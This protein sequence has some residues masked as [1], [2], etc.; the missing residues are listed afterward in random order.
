MEQAGGN[1][2]GRLPDTGQFVTVEGVRLHSVSAGAGVPVV[3]LHGNA[4]FAHDFA[5]L[6]QALP[7]RGFHAVAFDRPGHG[8]SASPTAEPATV[9]VQARLLRGALQALGIERPIVVG[10]SWGGALALA[11]ALAYEPEVAALV[12]LAPAVY[13]EPPAYGAGNMLLAVPLLSTLLIRLSGAHIGR[14]I[15][16][17]LH[18]AFAPDPLPAD[19]LHSAL[20]SWSRTAQV[21]ATVQD[22]M[23]YSPAT[24]ALS[25]R[26]NAV[27]V[28]TVIMTGDADQL[29]DPVRHAYPLHRALPHAELI[30][31]PATGHMLPHTRTQA[32]LAAIEAAHARSH[33]P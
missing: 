20:A 21:K 4:G 18:K 23:N 19:Y 30:V 32:V 7:A 9:A 12:L 31:L 6:M 11:Y 10:H 28:P 24:H 5:A 14:E 3:L 26:Y 16:R 27:G 13:P 8:F 2:A 15:E 25:A 17:N 29:V 22:E 33:A 1:G